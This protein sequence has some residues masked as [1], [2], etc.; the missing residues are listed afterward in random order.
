MEIS[1]FGCSYVRDKSIKFANS[2]PCACRGSTRQKPQYG[3]MTL[4]FQCFT[5]VLLMIYGSL[6]PSGIY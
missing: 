3:M 2:P 6:F 5:A 4:T 1:A